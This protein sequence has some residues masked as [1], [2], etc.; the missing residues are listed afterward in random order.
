MFTIHFK[1][2][3]Y[4][5][6]L[7]YEAY[8]ARQ[9]LKSH[10]WKF[11][12]G[13]HRC[14]RNC[15]GCRVG[16]P[17]L[18][19]FTSR[20]ENAAPF[21]DNFDEEARAA[22]GDVD[23]K[24]TE[25]ESR[26]GD[27]DI[28]V[29]VPAGLSYM[30]YQRAGIKWIMGR[31]CTLL[32]DEMG[33]GKT[34]QILG[35][36]NGLVETK[37][38][39]CV[40]PA[41]LTMNWIREAR[42]WLVRPVNAVRVY[43]ADDLPD[44][45][46]GDSINFLVTNY[47]LLINQKGKDVKE[48]MA[49]NGRAQEDYL[50]FRRAAMKATEEPN[51]ISRI[52]V[53]AHRPSLI[54]WERALDSK[55]ITRKVEFQIATDADSL[56][57]AVAELERELPEKAIAVVV[58]MDRRLIEAAMH[59]PYTWDIV[60]KDRLHVLTTRG[61]GRGLHDALMERKFDMLVLD[62]CH[63]ITNP[64]AQ[65]TI[66]IV[67]KESRR[68]E[69]KP[70]LISRANRL[71]F[72]TGTP[73]R[74]KPVELWPLLHALA[75]RTFNNFFEYALEFCA[76]V[77][78][79]WGWDFNNIINLKE[80]ERKA[81]LNRLQTILRTGT[82]HGGLM[83]RR[84]K[85]DVLKDMPPKIRHLQVLEA[86]T[87]EQAEAIAA[88]REAFEEREEHLEA[89]RGEA[90]L[91]E[92]RGDTKAYEAAVAE[93]R[94]A[95]R[96]AF[97]EMSAVRH[98]TGLAKVGPA[99]KY[100]ADLLEGGLDKVL[101]FC[102]H[103][104]VAEG[105]QEALKEYG[106]VK[107]TGETP[108]DKRMPIVDR[109][110]SDPNTRV[111]I[112]NIDAAGVGLTLTAASTVIMVEA[113]WVPALNSQAEDRAHRYGQQHTVHVQYLVFDG[114]ID[115]LILEKVLQKMEVVKEA[116]DDEIADLD[117]PTETLSTEIQE[118]PERASDEG[119]SINDRHGRPLVRSALKQPSEMT[120]VPD[121]APE[122]RNAALRAMQILAGRCDGALR[123]DDMGFSAQWVNAGHWL[124]GQADLGN[125]ATQLAI[126]I[127]TWHQRQLP[128]DLLTLLGIE[129]KG[130]RDRPLEAEGPPKR[131]RLVLQNKAWKVEFSSTLLDMPIQRTVW[132]NPAGMEGTPAETLLVEDGDTCFK[133][134]DPDVAFRVCVRGDDAGEVLDIE[135]PKPE[136]K[137]ELRWHGGRWQ[138]K[139]KQGWTDIEHKWLDTP[140]T[141]STARKAKQEAT[142]ERPFVVAPSP[143]VSDEPTP[144][145]RTPSSRTPSAQRRMLNILDPDAF[146]RMTELEGEDWA[147]YERSHDYEPTGFW[148]NVEAYK[149][150]QELGLDRQ[151]YMIVDAMPE[152]GVF[153]GMEE[154]GY[155]ILANGEIA[156][157]GDTADAN[158]R[159]KAAKIVR[160]V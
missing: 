16:L 142:V 138:R 141:K 81:I 88:E 29:P 15:E 66:A 41:S 148:M 102:V 71:V 139:L 33:L 11:H 35:A 65:Q 100:V 130:Q 74:N 157:L 111:F 68:S 10:G 132:W 125:K 127:A 39:L 146:D 34:I 124:A 115:Q 107:I 154:R 144:S 129:R 61:R 126:R 55:K 5:T 78:N 60:L 57:A 152:G 160:V 42:K 38:V 120:A 40:V 136:S 92:L 58:P 43:T 46:A 83:I 9:Q 85:A 44:P 30:P 86:E 97:E 93:L 22:I 76:A 159:S 37:E 59:K 6:R 69:G 91:A 80:S 13:D 2:G 67:G 3:L 147:A 84:M 143:T 47:E 24:I 145:S 133:A 72:A 150:L 95:Q 82:E 158:F 108:Q 62:E 151:G 8:A 54:D 12:W 90:T 4:Y 1:D 26:A 36:I 118:T 32:G 7:P 109:F 99:S 14:Y 50:G 77:K 122:V 25:A 23:L 105:L 19:N 45:P 103:R 101:V 75:P 70:G 119:I 155:T 114:S 96:I 135:V 21:I 98:R 106:P 31:R 51:A 140:A 117:V 134:A 131:Y 20:R 87:K 89:L 137:Y 48:V 123:R 149:T 63:K 110:Q 112:G 153:S 121:Y 28:D 79:R 53:V 128:D 64:K 113:T 27:A 18:T 94:K 17:K 56:H 156:L 52:L 116:L 104:D 73:I 49:T